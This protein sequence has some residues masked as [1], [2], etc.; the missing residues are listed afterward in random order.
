MCGC[1]K[2]TVVP[3]AL[4]Q[5]PSTPPQLDIDCNV[6]LNDLIVKRGMIQLLKTPENAGYINQ[7]LGLIDSMINLGNPCKYQID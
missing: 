4:Y 7:Q 5:A 6:T 1:S 2:N 3:N